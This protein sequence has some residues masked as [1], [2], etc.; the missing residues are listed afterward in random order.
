MTFDTVTII[1]IV[2]AIIAG[3]AIGVFVASLFRKKQPE[4][5]IPAEPIK[6][7][8]SATPAPAPDNS[9]YEKKISDQ[10]D[11]VARLK[12][13]LAETKSNLAA[14]ERTVTALT[15]GEN[16]DEA[17]KSL[18]DEI[19][20]LK[21]KVAAAEEEAEEYEDEANSYKKKY[22]D[23]SKKLTELSS[24]VEKLESE[25]KELKE[26]LE[27]KE[28]ELQEKTESLNRKN[29][30]IDF[31][32]EILTAK[33]ADSEDRRKIN[34]NVSKI[35]DLIK[36]DILD[37]LKNA[38]AITDKKEYQTKIWQ[39]ANL[40]RKTWIQGKKVIAF[41]GEFS[42]GKTS[43]VNR[44]LSQDNDNAPKLPVSSKATTAIATYISYAMDFASQ[45]TTNDGVL[46][47]IRRD[48]FEKV[49]K[50]ILSQVRMSSAIQYF[51]M[52]YNN[53]NLRKLS[54]LDTP[55]FN[56]NDSEDAE[57]TVNVINEADA[58]FWV[59]DANSGEINN[60][61]LEVIKNHLQGLPLYI[62]INKA[63]TKSPGE[64]DALEA[65]IKETIEKNG[66]AVRRYIR[67]SQKEPV[68]TLMD[69]IQD[70]PISN[71]KNSYLKEI[72]DLLKQR[73]TI[74]RDACTKT[75]S[76]LRQAQKD[77]ENC[78]TII[79]QD[80]DKI[81]EACIDARVLPEH[82]D[83]FFFFSKERHELSPEQFDRLC[84]LL[85]NIKKTSS[86][87]ANTHCSRLQ[88][89][90]KKLQSIQGKLDELKEERSTLQHALD[91]LT[92]AMKQWNP[93]FIKQI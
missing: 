22:K 43:I 5:K 83:G 77:N 73:L 85:D 69:A 7:D 29:E 55:G 38:D 48:T 6:D 68:S 45:F 42:A 12:N 24:A 89:S 93:E 50:E 80:T 31:V 71:D 66:I 2:V 17:V 1:L 4:K 32:N 14:S 58:L 90:S 13:S 67:F 35:E 88:N 49:N 87:V 78:M 70:V 61:S 72:Y 59:F 26:S 46:K 92:A 18:M 91:S 28:D 47:T 21:K 37:V 53:E 16:A 8:A 51:V 86:L 64:L 54:I 30:A 25:A 3:V 41:V 75:N 20:S 10:T 23:S 57:R 74:A 27:E 40:Q 84:N 44:I 52:S 39:W 33:E 65:H 63:D 9:E 34:Q 15:T 79:G 82:K 60:S 36:D 19:V 56:S 11:E 62:V 81:K 76:E